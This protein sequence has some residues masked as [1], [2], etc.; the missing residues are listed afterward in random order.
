MQRHDSQE[1][2]EAGSPRAAAPPAS[3]E[4]SPLG[5]E[6]RSTK[7]RRVA[8]TESPSTSQASVVTVFS[9]A[10]A[11]DTFT[12]EGRSNS[13]YKA[14]LQAV[15]PAGTTHEYAAFINKKVAAKEEGVWTTGQVQ[16]QHQGI[17]PSM[18]RR[19]PADSIPP[20][21]SQPFSIVWA[22]DTDS[23]C[24]LPCLLTYVDNFANNRYKADTTRSPATGGRARRASNGAA[25]PS[26]LPSSSPLPHHPLPPRNAS[27]SVICSTQSVFLSSATFVFLE[28]CQKVRL[29]SSLPPV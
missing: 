5:Y 19:V 14:W 18:L 3:L 27:P 28:L 6:A 11:T 16:C 25:A 22:D 26:S 24:D 29:L 2:M 7:R 13:A 20:N 10:G 17:M 15:Q 12:F 1:R 9:A 8:P 21:K 23:V 4:S